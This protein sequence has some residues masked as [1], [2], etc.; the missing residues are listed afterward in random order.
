LG[1]KQLALIIRNPVYKGKFIAHRYQHVKV[2]KQG[3]TP[4]E[5]IRFVQKKIE[6][7]RDEWIIVPVPPIVSPELWVRA[8]KMLEK[9]AT[10]GRRSAKNPYLLIGLAKCASCGYTFIGGRK[11]K[12]GKKGQIW[13][14]CFYRCA[15][16]GQRIP[17]VIKEIAGPQSQISCTI[18]EDAVWS[19][20]CTVL[21]KPQILIDTLELD[22]AAGDNAQLTAEIKLL[23]KRYEKRTLRMRNCT[24]RIWQ[25]SSMSESSPRKESS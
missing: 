23:E 19:T 20:V 10:M 5:P 16:R 3:R 18:L 9:N 13:R 17:Y 2:R 12:T 25:K 22:F 4:D 11:K 8:N 24:E 21:L 6:R 14:P 1:T 15:A 7:P